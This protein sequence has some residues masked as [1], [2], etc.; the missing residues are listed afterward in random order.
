MFAVSRDRNHLISIDYEQKSNPIA[1]AHIYSIID[2]HLDSTLI[3]N[4]ARDR[5]LLNI[6]SKYLGCEAKIL[7]TQ[8]WYT[9]PNKNTSNHI[10]F[11]YHIDLDDIKFLKL[12]FYL[13]DVNSENGPHYIISGT[14]RGLNIF[15][16]FNRQ[17]SH[18][19]AL[20]K[21]SKDITMILGAKGEGFFEDT[22]TYH[23]G[24]SVD[25]GRRLLFQIE[26]GVSSKQELR[27]V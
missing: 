26:Y 14:N 13:D 2:P 20:R 7:T 22:F 1:S 16:F 10:D 3:D 9:F 12:F 23:K 24:T 21:F 15:K 8:F 17:I 18:Q 6:A 11:G 5:R 27:Q 25:E 19:C 4:I